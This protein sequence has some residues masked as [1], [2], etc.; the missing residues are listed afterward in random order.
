MRMV[1]KNYTSGGKN[2]RDGGAEW[3]SDCGLN[4]QDEQL[5]TR[6]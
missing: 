3:Y 1:Q 4:V 2:N 6:H 5:T